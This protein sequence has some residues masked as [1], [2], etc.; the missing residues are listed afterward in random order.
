MMGQTR[1]SSTLL[2]W[3]VTEETVIKPAAAALGPDIAAYPPPQPALSVIDRT[4]AVLFVHQSLM[5]ECCLD[6]NKLADAL[7][8][9]L[10][11]FPTLGCR[12]TKDTVCLEGMTGPAIWNCSPNLH[13]C[14]PPAFGHHTC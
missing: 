7:G 4:S 6:A 11:L 5:F 1:G 2:P 12:A 9:A 3:T 8:Q 10:A 14:S 13:V